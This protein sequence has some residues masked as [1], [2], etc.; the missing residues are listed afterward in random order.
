MKLVADLHIHSHFSRATSPNLTFEHL[1]CW[2]QLKGIHVVG[3][4]DIAHPGWLA[5]MRE[6]LAPAEEGLYRLKDEVAAAVQTQVPPACHAPVRFILGGEIS[7]IYKRGEKTRKVHNVVFAPSFEA[8]ERLQARL[9]KIG[10]IRSDGRPILGLDSRDLLEIVLETDSAC[11]LIPAHIW[12]P[13]FSLLGSKSGFDS[14]AECF[15]DLTPHIFALETGLSSD[16]PMNWRV[17]ALDRYT[18]VSNSDAHSPEKLGREANLFDCELAYGALFDAL[19][20]DLTPSAPPSLRGKGDGG[21]GGFLGTIEFFPEEGK[22][23]L[24]GHRKCNIVW[25]HVTTLAHGGLCAV[26]GKEVTVGVM[27][28]VEKL[29]DRP[30]GGRPA[31]THPFISLIPLSEVLGEVYGV[32]AGSKQVET[33]YMKLLARLGP[34]LA[35]LADVPL[36]EIT[37]AGGERLAEGIGRMRRGEVTAEAGYDGEYG[38]IRLFRG[39]A[40]VSAAQIGLFGGETK[41]EKRKTKGAAAVREQAALYDLTEDQPLNA[42]QQVGDSRVAQ[43][44][45]DSVASDLSG[46]LTP[47]D[48]VSRNTQHATR[49]TQ[50]AVRSTQNDT[51]LLDT[52]NPQQRA[53]VLCTDAPLVIVAGPGTGKTRTLTVRIAYLV[54]EKQVAPESILA[55][56][57]TNKAAGEMAERLTGLLGAEIAGRVTVKTFHAFGALLLREWAACLGLSPDFAICTEEDRAAVL[58]QACPELKQ[59]EVDA[60]LVQISEAKNRLLGPDNLRLK[61]EADTAGL[62][63]AYRC[64][65]AALRASDVVDFDDLILLPVR[66]LEDHSDVLAAVRTR[67]HWISVDEYQDVNLAQYRLLRLLTAPAP[68][69]PP[70]PQLWGEPTYPPELGGRGANLCVIGDPDQAIYG[71]RGADPRYF[72]RF[73]QDYPGAVTL[74]LNRNYRST[75]LILDAAVQVIAKN[76]DRKAVEIF[77]D[78]VEH[79]KLDVYRAPT[80]KAEAEY[81]VH[82]IE[83]MVGGTSYFSLDSDR[84]TGDTPAAA[85]S[86][87]DF[88]VLYRLSA[89]S[90]LLVEA[91]DRSGIPYQTVGQTPLYAHK[92][93]REVLAHLWLLHNPRSRLHL[94][95]VLAAGGVTLS[96]EDIRELWELGGTQGG[97]LGEAFRCAARADGRKAAQRRRLDGLATLWHELEGGR[98]VAPVS[99]LIEQVSR[100]MAQE[101]GEPLGDADAERIRQ[102]G[103]RAAP[104]DNRLADFL[105]STALQSET[106]VYDPRADRV[107]LMSLHASKGL[108]FPVVFIVGC[109]EGLLPYERK[110][111]AVDVEEERRL[112]YVGMT[113]AGQKLVLAH[114]RTRFLFGQRMENA[115]SRFVGDIEAALKEWQ[116]MKYRRPEQ[117]PE[118]GQMSLF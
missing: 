105:E 49:S 31:R 32:G 47:L 115:P 62:V 113:R 43:Q 4:G 30:A 18:L 1:T 3:T 89:Q 39:A 77:S 76:P 68:P 23:H 81:V 59:G 94:A 87:A 65:E 27:H 118:S 15:G 41:N 84:V 80:D 64:Y 82:Q 78:F 96:A 75:Q 66:L 12:T 42:P 19:W 51:G 36:E 83:Q 117:K 70:A 33:E 67:Y 86:F 54:L 11:R 5:E 56:T 90:R 110:G 57:F 13:W 85:R 46:R 26:C 60:Y 37:A 29:A 48:V 24:D 14:V 79:V 72:I 38:V 73:E 74:S 2:A 98:R 95:T 103:L 107:T 100:F 34:E 108:E 111:E 40:S 16:P 63:D 114:A 50:Y 99:Q 71:F 52:L 53:A 21:I 9:E 28:R 69:A 58:R 10:N 109:E 91:F 112:F 61:S 92:A 102:L 20:K 93:V 25:D 6:K 22:Y 17:S 44:P 55:I 101:R 106:D 35:I 97:A 7:N 8:V 45:G 116:E 88:A 104:F